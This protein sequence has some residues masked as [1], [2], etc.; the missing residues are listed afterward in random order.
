VSY[1]GNGRYTYYGRGGLGLANLIN[2]YNIPTDEKIS[3]FDNLLTL[4]SY[5]DSGDPIA[6]MLKKTKVFDGDD[7]EQ[8]LDVIIGLGSQKHPFLTPFIGNDLFGTSSKSLLSKLNKL[9]E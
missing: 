9:V 8:L 3:I 4:L 5:S 1:I 6:E 2:K 7:G